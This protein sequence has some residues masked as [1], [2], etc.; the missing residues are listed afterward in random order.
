MYKQKSKSLYEQY[1]EKYPNAKI[2]ITY[3]TK[4]EEELII[5][6]NIPISK[7]QQKREKQNRYK[8]E[9]KQLSNI[10]KPN[11]LK[12]KFVSKLKRI[13][14]EKL[15]MWMQLNYLNYVCRGRKHYT[16]SLNN[17]PKS[18][19][20]NNTTEFECQR[21]KKPRSFESWRNSAEFVKMTPNG[22]RILEYPPVTRKFPTSEMKIL[23]LVEAEKI[24]NIKNNKTIEIVDI[25]WAGK[26]EED[27]S[28]SLKQNLNLKK[29]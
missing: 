1:K 6:N 29:S 28:I 18:H 10:N 22:H 8:I 24:T 12:F 16:Y 4:G 15:A 13:E 3:N 14:E 2:K 5:I 25:R 17:S 7:R 27:N 20:D 11:E 26:K 21:D 19:W 23:S 9:L